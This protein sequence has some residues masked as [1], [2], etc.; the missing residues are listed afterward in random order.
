MA[1]PASA[2]ASLMDP[3]L[4]NE[5]NMLKKI[6][7]AIDGSEHAGHAAQFAV[8]LCKQTGAKLIVV[9]VDEQRP[10]TGPL[11][12]M[13]KSEGMSRAQVFERILEET[14]ALCGASGISGV[15]KIQA[16]GDPV[17]EIIKCADNEK[18]DLIVTGTRGLGSIGRILLGSVS[19]KLIQLS[20]HPCLVV[21]TRT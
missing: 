15:E 18:V 20:R 11:Q 1:L 13:Q 6:L 10:L 19:S 21:P 16:A 4:P 3:A 7:I 9:T 5:D 8:T 14:M 2:M 12:E 17:T